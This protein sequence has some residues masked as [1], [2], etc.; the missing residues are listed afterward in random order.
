MARRE[1]DVQQMLLTEGPSLLMRRL[2]EVEAAREAVVELGR[3]LY[4]AGMSWGQLAR[5]LGVSPQA[6]RQRFG[7]A[8]AEWVEQWQDLKPWEVDD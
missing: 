5:V 3:D 7:P 6:A 4:L 1:R 8:V 2:D